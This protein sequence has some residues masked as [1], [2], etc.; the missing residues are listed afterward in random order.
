MFLW[1]IYIK[2]EFS[3]ILIE[4]KNKI[5]LIQCLKDNIDTNNTILEL[6]ESIRLQYNGEE[7]END[8]FYELHQFSKKYKIIGK[9]IDEKNEQRYVQNPRSL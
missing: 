7:N 8:L 4:A 3:L 2:P 9:N 5:D 6:F 1:V